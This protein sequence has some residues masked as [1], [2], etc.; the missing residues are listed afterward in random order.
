VV[1]PSRKFQRGDHHCHGRK[2]ISKA[3]EMLGFGAEILI[4][5]YI[6]REIQ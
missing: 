5:E 3:M 1:K 2:E 4:E 6:G